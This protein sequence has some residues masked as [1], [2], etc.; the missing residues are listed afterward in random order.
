MGTMPIPTYI[1][2]SIDGKPTHSPVDSTCY[3]LDTGRWYLNAGGV[4]V[5]ITCHDNLGV[6]TDSTSV[7][8]GTVTVKVP[9][10]QY[11]DEIFSHPNR[12]WWQ[13]W[14]GGN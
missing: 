3:E 4:W 1:G 13:F 8:L 14:K 5:D 11:H 7:D 12:K 10:T 6:L 2:T 9:K